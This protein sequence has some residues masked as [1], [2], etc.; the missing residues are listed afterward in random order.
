MG[1]PTSI[2]FIYFWGSNE[3]QRSCDGQGGA[4]RPVLRDNELTK[5]GARS[6]RARTRGQNPLVTNNTQYFKFKKVSCESNSVLTWHTYLF[7]HRSYVAHLPSMC[8][9]TDIPHM[10]SSSVPRSKISHF[11]N[12]V[13]VSMLYPILLTLC[14]VLTLRACP[15]SFHKCYTHPLS[16]KKVLIFRESYVL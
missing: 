13:P 7:W 5:E 8:V 2:N 15:L 14:L 4:Q 11:S 3:K 12:S 16:L 6:A 1:G 10:P 9:P